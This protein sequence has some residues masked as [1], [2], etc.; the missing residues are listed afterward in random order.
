MALTHYNAFCEHAMQQNGT[1]PRTPLEELTAFPKTHWLILRGPLRNTLEMAITLQPADAIF[2]FRGE[3]R[4][5]KNGREGRV[6][7]RRRREGKEE[8][9]RGGGEWGT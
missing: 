4:E 9:G 7:E 2:G 8:S 3:E 1:A 6:R 5:G